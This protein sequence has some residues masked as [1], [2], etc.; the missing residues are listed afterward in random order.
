MLDELKVLVETV[1]TIGTVGILVI[2]LW[3]GKQGWWAWGHEHARVIKE[4]DQ[5]LSLLLSA[6]ELGKAALHEA[7][8]ERRR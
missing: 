6:H 4:R 5:L 3:G 8:Q 7:V 1:H 2:V